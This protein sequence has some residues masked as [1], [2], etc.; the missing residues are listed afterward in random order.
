MNSI[1]F[2]LVF[3]LNSVTILATIESPPTSCQ[4]KCG[5][6]PIKYPLGSGFGC[7]VSTHLSLAHHL[8]H[9]TATS[10]PSLK[11]MNKKM[12]NSSSQPMP[13]HTQPSTQH[14]CLHA[15]PCTLLPTS[16]FQL[17][18]SLFILIGCHPP[19]SAL[20]SKGNP[21][22]DASYNHL[23]ASLHSCPSILSLGLPI[24]SSTDTCCGY[25]PANLNAKGD[26]DINALRCASYVSVVSLG[27]IPT[28]PNRC[29]Y[30]LA[31]KYDQVGLDHIEMICNACEK[32]DGVCGYSPPK[33]NF[34]CVCKNGNSS[35]DCY[36]VNNQVSSFYW[37]SGGSSYRLSAFLLLFLFLSELLK[38]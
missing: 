4:N 26:L 6:I 18:P 14:R 1:F 2:F 30:G 29:E 34:V 19:T 22:C 11:T 31:L 7:R 5:S 36:N 37:T 33:N 12:S 3:S 15:Y 10:S 17:G 24:Y 8:S 13:A 27:D 35:S 20:Y 25:S 21:I 23:C 32:S 28:D 38:L 16:T 9:Q